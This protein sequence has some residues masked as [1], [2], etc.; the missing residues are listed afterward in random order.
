MFKKIFSIGDQ[1]IICDLGNEINKEA[2]IKTIAI[3]NYIN[4]ISNSDLKLGI[5]NT[6]PSYNKIVIQYD[7]NLT[8]SKKIIN[9]ISTIKEKDLIFEKKNQKIEIPIC[10]DKEYGIDLNNI[11]RQNNLSIPEIIN[12]HLNTEFYVYMI[13]F[14]PGFPFM[15]DLNKRL[16]TSRLKTPRLKVPE[17][18]V[19]IVE[20][21]C[22]I[23]PYSSPGGWNIVGK[24]T[25]KLFNKNNSKP[26]VL[27]PGFEVKFKSINK[28]QFI[29]LENNSE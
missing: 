1:G 12:L 6:I 25:S 7:L 3:F 2:S 18:S 16:F 23:Y 15:G 20:K 21:F 5:K 4:K 11:S 29:S 13:G 22:A 24:T 10:Y 14:M 8:N 28:S 9:F 27:L 19:A 17:R 26:T